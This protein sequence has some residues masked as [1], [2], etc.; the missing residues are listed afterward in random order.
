MSAKDKSA[1]M[2]ILRHTPEFKPHE[3]A[4]AEEVI[5]DYLHDPQGTG[6]HALVADGGRQVAGYI[7]YGPTPCTVGT[8]DIYWMVV[9]GEKRGQGIGGALTREAE[10]AI[11][12]AHGR[13]ILVETSSSPIYENTRNFYLS[14]GYEFIGRIPDFYA[15]GDDLLIMQKRLD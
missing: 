3:V 6:Y 4:V 11:R 10:E 2:R 7:C 1:L 13:L 15:P 9:A 14:Q 5:D 8:W 12:Q